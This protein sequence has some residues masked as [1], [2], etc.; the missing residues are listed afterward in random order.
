MLYRSITLV[1]GALVDIIYSKSL[2]VELSVA[3]K[4]APAGLVTADVERIDFTLE[5]L[6]SLWASTIELGIGIFLLEREVG[7][8]CIAPAVVAI[9]QYGIPLGKLA[10]MADSHVHVQSLHFVDFLHFQAIAK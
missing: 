6:H 2:E 9:R 10:Y 8:A 4:A 7:W 3:Q 5:K 1:R